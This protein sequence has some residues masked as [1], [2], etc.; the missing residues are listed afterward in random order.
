MNLDRCRTL[1]Q[2]FIE[3]NPSSCST[4]IDFAE[5]EA[6][7][8]EQ[9]RC[10][11]IYELAIQQESLDTPE[12]MWKKYIDFEIS[13][14]NRE[15][16]EELYDRLLQ[17]AQHSKVYISYAQY[18]SAFEMDKA[19]T[20]LEDGISF[21]KQAGEGE[22]RYQLLLALKGLEESIEDNDERIEKVGKRQ[23][24]KV[25]KSR[26]DPATGITEDYIDYI[27][28]DDEANSIQ[29]KMLEAAKEWKMKM[30]KTE[31]KEDNNN[32][33]DSK[34]V[35]VEEKIDLDDVSDQISIVSLFLYFSDFIHI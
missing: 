30:M 7:L 16:V 20:I 26:V 24:K 3:Y 21:F 12:L 8:A 33:R 28:P 31:R 9:E 14:E 22:M 35:K 1:Y 2:K 27:F 34:R 4:W 17:L 15:K 25:K 23:A 18:E 11:A 13:L 32:E 5:F 19:R 29:M 6:N 10:E